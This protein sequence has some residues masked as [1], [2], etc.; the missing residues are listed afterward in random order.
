MKEVGMPDR[1]TRLAQRRQANANYRSDLRG[2]V[3]MFAGLIV[4]VLLLACCVRNA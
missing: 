2:V 1:S 4:L 3:V